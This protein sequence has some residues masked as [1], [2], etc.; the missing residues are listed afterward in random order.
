MDSLNKNFTLKELL[1]FALPTVILMMFMSLYTMVDGFFISNFIGETAFSAINIVFPF[2]S[3]VIAF[4][5]MISTGASAIISRDIG[6]GNIEEGR[7]NLSL[8]TIFGL[9]ISFVLLSLGVIFPQEISKFLGATDILMGYSIDYLVTIALFTPF[10]ILQMLSQM[11]FILDGKPKLGLIV[12]VMGGVTNIILDYVFIVIFDF[13]MMGAAMATGMGYLVPGISYLIYFFKRK[14]NGLYFKKPVFRKNILLKTFTNGSSEMVTNLS[15]TIISLLFNL[16]ILRFAGEEG[17]AAVGVVMYIQFIFISAFIG[18]TM[19]V[20]PI[21]GYNYG[22][23]NSDRLKRVF[24][25]SLKVIIFSSIISYI[26]CLIGGDYVI[27]IFLSR[28]SETFSLTQHGLLIFSVSFL[29]MGLNVFASGLFTAFSNGK[30]SAIISFVRTLLLIV[31]FI[32]VLPRIIGIDGVWLAIP[33]AEVVSIF[34]SI[35]FFKKYK[36]VYNY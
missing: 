36:K 6:Q 1:K 12:G 17:V 8:V 22:A 33:L 32:L 30:V 24:S 28:T 16:V 13:S 5:T 10:A 2:I 9:I 35:Y 18:Y 20:A 14:E 19:G 26:L 3:L 25:L 15:A 7:E 4:G 34:V 27:D 31:I 11:F 21:I 23:G 29:F